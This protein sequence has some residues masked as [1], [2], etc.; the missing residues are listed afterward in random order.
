MFLTLPALAAIVTLTET[1]LVQH[2]LNA[3]PFQGPSFAFSY[4]VVWTYH[5][6]DTVEVIFVTGREE[7]NLIFDMIPLPHSPAPTILVFKAP[8]NL[9]GH[10]RGW[11]FQKH[12]AAKYE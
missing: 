10:L 12:M 4:G 9:K 7:G 1:D 11:I 3:H 6:F 8:D 5:I 2:H